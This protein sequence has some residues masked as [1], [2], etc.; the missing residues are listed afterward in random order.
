MSPLRLRTR[1]MVER[2]GLSLQPVLSSSWWI[3]MAPWKAYRVCGVSLRTSFCRTSTILS[4]NSFVILLG[5]LLGSL[6]SSRYH[7]GSLLFDR[8]IHWYTQSRL[9]SRSVWISVGFLPPWS[10]CTHRWRS[11]IS[12]SDVLLFFHVFTLLVGR[13]YIICRYSHDTKSVGYLMKRGP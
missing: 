1:L 11:S 4:S 7:C 9:L 5:L 6:E 12:C 8:L 10:N 13:D 3:A 2:F